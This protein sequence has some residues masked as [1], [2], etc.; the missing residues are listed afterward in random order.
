M[1]VQN[2]FL[3]VCLMA[4]LQTKGTFEVSLEEDLTLSYSQKLI[5]DKVRFIIFF[6]IKIKRNFATD[7]CNNFKFTV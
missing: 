7:I 2:S 1:F 5:L 3:A 6:A 4:I